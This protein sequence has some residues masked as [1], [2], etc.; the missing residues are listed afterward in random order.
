V[1]EFLVSE[2]NKKEREWLM[3]IL[4]GE[5]DENFFSPFVGLGN[6]EMGLSG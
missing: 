5:I 1:G 6:A 4:E 2:E 3:M